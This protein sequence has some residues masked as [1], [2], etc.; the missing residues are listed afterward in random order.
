MWKFKRGGGSWSILTRH[1][2]HG[3]Y[4]CSDGFIG[5]SSIHNRQT[6]QCVTKRAH[7]HDSAL[8]TRFI[9][10]VFAEIK[11]LFAPEA[12]VAT[13]VMPTATDESQAAFRTFVE[14]REDGDDGRLR[15]G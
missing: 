14:V 8:G 9:I 3:I 15:K 12:G 11:G 5:E 2:F 6:F 7:I 13:G 4:E 1:F 10:I